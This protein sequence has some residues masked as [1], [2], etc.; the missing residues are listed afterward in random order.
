M[1]DL[2]EGRD[3]LKVSEDIATGVVVTHGDYPYLNDTPETHAGAPIYGLNKSV[4][5]NFHLMDVCIRRAP[6]MK[7]D[8]VI[9]EP[10]MC[11]AGNYIGVAVGLGDT[12]KE[13]AE[14]AYEVADKI[15]VP[16]NLMLR[17]DIGKRLEKQ[18]PQLQK[19]GYAEG[20]SYE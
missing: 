4:L 13:S 8:E 5:K 2:L 12:V 1:A 17:N 6:T 16:S 19:K 3:T 11:T 14:A 10:M 15:S 18:L 9:E 7:G 20:M